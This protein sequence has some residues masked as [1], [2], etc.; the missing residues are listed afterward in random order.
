L[1]SLSV[2]ILFW[3]MLI[4]SGAVA[5]AY[6]LV[7]ERATAVALFAISMFSL[8][9][10]LGFPASNWHYVSTLSDWAIFPVAWYFALTSDRYWPIWFAAMQTLTVLTLVITPTQTGMPHLL[11]LN[12][13]GFWSLPALMMMTWGT[14][15]DWRERASAS[16]SPS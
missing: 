15:L 9:I 10:S 4:C 16:P 11:L 2:L 3:L 12:L 1:L 13:A 7:F 5:F 8:I 6:G 14:I